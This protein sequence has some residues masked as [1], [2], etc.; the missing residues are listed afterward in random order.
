MSTLHQTFYLLPTRLWNFLIQKNKAKPCF[1][2]YCGE[3]GISAS[4]ARRRELIRCPGI[5]QSIPRMLC[6]RSLRR[7]SADRRPAHCNPVRIPFLF[8]NKNKVD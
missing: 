8:T 6:D 3:A 4:L 5:A 2:S 7:R 1:L